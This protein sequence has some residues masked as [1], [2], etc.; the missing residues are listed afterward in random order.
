MAR[1]RP[2]LIGTDTGVAERANLLSRAADQRAIVIARSMAS[3][4]AM[5]ALGGD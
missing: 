1:R 4:A 3:T 5:A 2:D